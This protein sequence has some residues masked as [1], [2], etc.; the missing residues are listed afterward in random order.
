V[1]GS[2]VVPGTAPFTVRFSSPLSARTPNPVI[3]PSVAGSWA[4]SGTE[5]TF[6]PAMA[7]YPLTNVTITVPAG[8]NGMLAAS[9]RRLER[10]VLDHFQIEGASVTR[11]Q[12]LLSLLDY[13]PLTWR[14]AG[15]AIAP[16]DTAAQLQALYSPPAGAFSWNQ[17]GWPAQ[18]VSL[19]QPGVFN[20][21]TT[22]LVM[23]FQADHGLVV[24]GA[25][26]P[27]LFVAL[28]HA[29]AAN[30]VNTGGYNFALCNKQ[31]PEQLVIWHDGKSVL[32]TPANTG[33]PQSPTPDGV[34][35]VYARY[36]QEVMKGTNPDG[37]TYAD[38]VQFVAYFHQGD[39]VHYLPRTDY[40]IPQ[41]LGCIE[42]P[43]LQASEAWP[44][45]AYGTL[46][47]VIN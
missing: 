10:H 35:P 38:P 22:G 44:W 26:S 21:M 41:S 4:V 24:N 1:S 6:T 7:W 43:L 31:Q 37:S 46:V 14:A 8:S 20:T 30:V 12:Q 13:S 39:A 9:G 32:T 25:V 11:I 36:R 17:T 18:L 47:D 16:G 34:F 15:A 3:S 27:G 42:L 29:L 45:L 19:W 28:V 2:T 5:D 40:G 33:I 23:E